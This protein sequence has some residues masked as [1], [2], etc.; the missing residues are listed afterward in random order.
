M[1]AA[2][3]ADSGA[4]CLEPLTT[5]KGKHPTAGDDVQSLSEVT[6]SFRSKMV[7]T[8]VAAL[9]LNATAWAGNEKIYLYGETPISFPC[10]GASCVTCYPPAPNVCAIIDRGGGIPGGGYPDKATLYA[11]GV[12]T[13]TFNC[14]YLGPG[15]S[16]DPTQDA[17]LIPEP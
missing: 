14:I 10:G 5:A 13:S 16:G 17:A 7:L 8:S 3:G 4:C 6:M 1:C 12:Q 2:E 11:N 9:V 15:P